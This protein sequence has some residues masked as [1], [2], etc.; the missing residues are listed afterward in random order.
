M[1]INPHGEEIGQTRHWEMRVQNRWMPFQFR[2]VD[3]RSTGKKVNNTPKYVNFCAYLRFHTNDIMQNLGWTQILPTCKDDNRWINSFPIRAIKSSAFSWLN[4]RINV[5][6]P[7]HAVHCSREIV[8]E[9]TNWL[10][11]QPCDAKWLLRHSAGVARGVW[12]QN[13]VCATNILLVSKMQWPPCSKHKSIS[14]KLFLGQLAWFLQ[15]HTYF[16]IVFI[17]HMPVLLAV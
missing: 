12:R 16:S 17:P 2:Q 1:D 15:K 9:V 11:W 5:L 8:R 13:W 3:N 10:L 4:S 6:N 14:T 7:W